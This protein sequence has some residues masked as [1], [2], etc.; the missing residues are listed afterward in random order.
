MKIAVIEKY[1]KPSPQDSS[2]EVEALWS[3]SS[4]NVFNNHGRKMLITNALKRVEYSYSA[5][6]GNQA[7]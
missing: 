4:L 7:F 5:V 1:L 3:K 6:I 2:L